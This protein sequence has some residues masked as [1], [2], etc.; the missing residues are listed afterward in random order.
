M[1]DANY[2]TLLGR[3]LDDD[4]SVEQAE[5]LLKI[6]RDDP[7]KLEDM[8]RHLEIWQVFSELV[9]PHRDAE[10]FV[11]S[12]NTRIAADGDAERFLQEL[13]ERMDRDASGQSEG[14]AIES[15]DRLEPE[16]QP[17]RGDADEGL[18]F[19]APLEPDIAE[20][21][22]R[23]ER[24]LND[25]LAERERELRAQRALRRTDGSVISDLQGALEGIAHRVD[26]ALA[27]SAKAIVACSVV[28]GLLLVTWATIH[29]VQA[30]RTVAVLGRTVNAQWAQT[31]DSNELCPGSLVLQQGL[32]ELN[33]TKGARLIVQAPCELDLASPQKVVCQGGTITARV[34]PSAVGFVVDTPSAHVVDYGTEFG[35]SVNTERQSVVHVFEGQVGVRSA[36]GRKRSRLERLTEGQGALAGSNQG[37]RVDRDDDRR[38]RFIRQLSDKERLGIPGKRLSLAD[39]LGGGNGLGTGYA[40]AAIDEIT[41]QLILDVV[42]YTAGWKW[43]NAK[44]DHFPF[45]RV[46]GNAYIDGVFIPVTRTGVL[47]VSSEEHTFEMPTEPVNKRFVRGIINWCSSENAPLEKSTKLSLN[48]QVFDSLRHPAILMRRSRGVTFDLDAIR[49]DLPRT[50]IVRFTAVCGMSETDGTINDTVT[51]ADFYVLVDGRQ[52]FHALEMSPASEAA[53]VSVAIDSK[54]RFLTLIG[55]FTQVDDS[56][57]NRALYGDPALELAPAE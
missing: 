23:A 3:L 53:A 26:S 50:R 56:G 57:V 34:P 44:L 32:A 49:A 48:G 18:D 47:V 35:V 20:I 42:P 46:P 45:Q 24:Q 11:E 10:R 25:F 30:H 15:P 51:H 19:L 7:L 29:Y 14:M 33:F 52:R 12:L 40:N 27:F 13:E 4:L 17:L 31:P 39:M 16:T 36:K 8:C 54:D 43:F 21:R 22:C 41:G 2:D 1:R 55:A 5:A 9:C 6:V 38:N 28:L 37:L